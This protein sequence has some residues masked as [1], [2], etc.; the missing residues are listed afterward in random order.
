[1]GAAHPR[2]PGKLLPIL[3]LSIAAIALGLWTHSHFRHVTLRAVRVRSSGT[4][5][6]LEYDNIDWV[7]GKIGFFHQRAIVLHTWAYENVIQHADKGWSFDAYSGPPDDPFD[8][9]R[10]GP[11]LLGAHFRRSVNNHPDAI[12]SD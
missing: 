5:Y 9:S 4:N 6:R 11:S 1:M 10:L 8:F 7:A 2:R 12:I 3:S